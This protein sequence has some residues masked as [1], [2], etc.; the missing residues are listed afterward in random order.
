L[1][2]ALEKRQVPSACKNQDLTPH[3][4][5]LPNRSAWPLPNI[6]VPQANMDAVIRLGHR[7][8]TSGNKTLTFQRRLAYALT[9]EDM[10]THA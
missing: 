8:S 6:A 7:A 5:P 3:R 2:F 9:V 1:F 4:C 10:V